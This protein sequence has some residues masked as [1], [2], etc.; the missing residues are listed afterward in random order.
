VPF[1]AAFAASAAAD[2]EEMQFADEVGVATA[3]LVVALGDAALVVAAVVFCDDVVL[4]EEA[5]A[6]AF[7][8]VVAAAFST[9]ALVRAAVAGATVLVVVVVSDEPRIHVQTPFSQ[10]QNP[11]PVLLA[12]ALGLADAEALPVAVDVVDVVDVVEL[13][14][15]DGAVVLIVCALAEAVARG[16]GVLLVADALGDALDELAL[17][18]AALEA[19]CVD[20][21]TVG[22][23]SALLLGLAAIAGAAANATPTRATI[24]LGTPMAVRRRERSVWARRRWERAVAGT[25]H[26]CSVVGSVPFGPVGPGWAACSMIWVFSVY[27]AA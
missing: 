8:L 7:E 22:K 23:G 18:L 6:L 14:V 3:L 11:P 27:S 24:A 21:H 15:V 25:D 1:A 26:S 19:D 12:E 10:P 16:V 20:E 5:L 2:A 13:L 17:A 9:L 4:F